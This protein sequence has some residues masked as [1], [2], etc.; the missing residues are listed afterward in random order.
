[1]FG[2]ISSVIDAA[3]N[4]G[5]KLIEDKDKKTEFAFKMADLAERHMEALLNKDTYKWIDALVKLSYA[6]EQIVKG[7]FRP[8]G[9]L[10][11]AGFAAYCDTH[12]VQLSATIETMLY[13]APFAW[14]Y[15]RHTDKQ[16][17]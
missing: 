11:L 15:S 7:L 9:S 2:L 3:A 5:G 8:I 17:D 16:K 10:V 1:M 13:G 12:D 14:G 6:S 4:L